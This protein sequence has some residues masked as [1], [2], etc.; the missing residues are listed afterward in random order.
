MFDDKKF[1]KERASKRSKDLGRYLRYIFNGHLVIVLFFLLG[2]AAFY[3]QQWVQT[4]S[5]DFPV[6]LLMA[7][8][9][10]VI[11]TF[12]PVYTF[13]S[14]ADR[15]FLLPLENRLS[16]YF[17]RSGLL[18]IVFQ[19]YILLLFLAAFMPLYVQVSGEGFQAF[20]QFFIVLLC[21]KGW[22][23]A[24]GWKI[25]YYVQE[26]VHLTDKLIRFCLN[27]AFAYLL[28]D[29]AGLQFLFLEG[30]IMAL[31]YFYFA[32]QTRDKGL[33]W[34]FLI[35]QEEK[36][37]TSFYR[38]ANLFTDVP[39]LKDTV[40]RRKWLDFI[41]G[42]LPYGQ[43]KTYLHFYVLAFLRSGDYL[44]L[45]IR[46]TLIGGV[47]LYLVSFGYGKILLVLVF[48]YLTG[49]QLL[50]L[51]N[52]YQNKLWVGIYP[53][54]KEL[55]NVAFQS[56]LMKILVSQ[57]LLFALLLLIKGDIMVSLASA[58]AGI[59]FSYVFVYYY[60]KKRFSS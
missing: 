46:L 17:L 51:G 58:V 18:S 34:E 39:K 37:M 35:D 22:N 54:K 57:A 6:A 56:L 20:F 36:R 13:L 32:K 14:D 48:L 3:Y 7:I 9:F 33:K 10:G 49:F 12:S 40:K 38:L 41:L 45:F 52:H 53:L 55:K 29:Q 8:F 44:G 30:A 47:A 60:N 43:D 24:I 50:R 23:T 28:F 16:T 15:I 27:T 1:W 11:L 4:L 25:Q 19:S 21:L 42:G 2:T 59:V 5:G 31:L 26:S